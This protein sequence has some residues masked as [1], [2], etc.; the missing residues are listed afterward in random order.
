[1]RIDVK[2]GGG[3]IGS[4]LL[5]LC[6]SGIAQP[7]G[8]TAFSK[9]IGA[10]WFIGDSITQSNADGDGNGSPRKSL[11]DLL[12]ANGY[13]FSFTGHYSAIVDL[14]TT[15]GAPLTFTVKNTG[16]LAMSGIAVTFSGANSAD[17]AVTAAPATTLAVG[18]KTTFTV[19][20]TPAAAGTRLATMNIASNDPVKN[21]FTLSLKGT[22]N[23]APTFAG[24]QAATSYQTATGISVVKLLTKAF[25]ADG[26]SLVVALPGASSAHSGTVVMQSGAILYTPPAAFS[27]ADTFAVT[28]TDTG[29]ASAG[30]TV[31]VTVGPAPDSGGA[32]ALNAPK[33]TVLTDGNIELRC[34]GI[35]GQVYQ[36]Q[37]SSDLSHWTTLFTGAADAVGT[38]SFTDV[39]PPAP[40]GYYRLAPP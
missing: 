18:A 40:N 27:G 37:R 33:L 12:V 1:M 17:Y 7:T 23:T 3:I 4:L 36:V 16:R 21:P 22:G 32:N 25:D 31:S 11:Y 13:T 9:N 2:K 29:G 6:G 39:N 34:Q 38:L 35:P 26:D 20:F 5:A 19:T 8:I 28:L 14:L 30:G 15:T 24:Y 10:V